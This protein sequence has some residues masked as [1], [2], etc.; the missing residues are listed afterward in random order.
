MEQGAPSTGSTTSAHNIFF[1]LLYFKS[2]RFIAKQNKKSLNANYIFCANIL[3]LSDVSVLYCSILED[4]Q[5]Q[6]NCRSKCLC[7]API[8]AIIR[9][10]VS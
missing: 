2:K 9:F 8:R 7:P 4:N 3:S 10:K 1:V 5:G 6:Q